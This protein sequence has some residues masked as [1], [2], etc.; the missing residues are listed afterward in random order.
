MVGNDNNTSIAVQNFFGGRGDQVPGRD[1]C[2]Q[3]L[4]HLTV[5][6]DA[7]EQCRRIVCCMRN[8]NTNKNIL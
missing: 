8:G 1:H 3:K 6:E 5:G 2:F 4:H 7:A